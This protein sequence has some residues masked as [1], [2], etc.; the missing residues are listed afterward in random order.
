MAVLVVLA[1]GAAALAGCAQR[2]REAVEGAEDA[3]RGR[4]LEQGADVTVNKS[5][6]RELD[7]VSA[8]VEIENEKDTPA[9]V[10]IRLMGPHGETLKSAD[11]TVPPHDT[12]AFRVRHE[13][14]EPKGAAGA[15]SASLHVAQGPVKVE[16]FR[17]DLD[18]DVI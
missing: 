2:A 14:R 3:I 9:T 1:V 18:R 7:A 11:R 10:T 4:T 15:Y 13:F 16:E 12:D 6:A 17:I 8:K 5:T